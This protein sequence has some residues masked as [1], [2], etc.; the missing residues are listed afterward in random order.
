VQA[1]LTSP[2]IV[3]TLG[4]TFA[5]DKYFYG[6]V[7]VSGIIGVGNYIGASAPLVGTTGSLYYD[8]TLNALQLSNGSLWQ[9]VVDGVTGVGVVAAY[10]ATVTQGG[11]LQ[12]VQA[13]LTSPGIVTT[14][15]QTFAGDKYFFGSV[16]VSGIIG[17]GNYTGASAPPVGTTGSLYYDT[18]LNA[19]ELSNGS[20]CTS[21]FTRKNANT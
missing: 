4:Q 3:T 7:G 13:G 10:G 19:L 17:V 18:T 9:T 14:T 6:S 2:G 11:Y 20:T 1:G 15:G 21:K 12:L 16:G 8:N 5:G